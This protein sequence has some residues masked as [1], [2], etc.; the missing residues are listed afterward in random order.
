MKV[1]AADYVPIVPYET[2]WLFIGNGQRYDVGVDNPT[3]I[4][5]ADEE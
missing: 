3:C 1:I 5:Y 4:N 2:D